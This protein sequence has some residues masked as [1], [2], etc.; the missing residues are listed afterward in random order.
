VV[1][2]SLSY[3]MR[4][5]GRVNSHLTIDTG[6]DMLSRVT[7]YQALLP[8]DT[9][10]IN[11]AGV[12]IPPTQLFR[13]AQLIGLGWYADVAIDITSRLKLIPSLR[14]DGYLLDGIERS[15]V[16]PRLV[17]RYALSPTLSLKAYVGQFSQPP[18]PEALD[19]RFGNPQVGIEHAIHSGLGYEWNPDR[20]WSVDSEIYYV[21]RYDLAVNTDAIIPA[22][23]P[24]ISESNT[25]P[26]RRQ[27]PSHVRTC[28]GP[29]PC[30]MF[31]CRAAAT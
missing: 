14:L 6:L 31:G 21:N 11:N 20:L 10:L 18:Q 2:D 12:D 9:G 22:R 26:D 8:I 23:H 25:N 27:S 30:Q 16:D 24:F 3:R 5:H 13:G 7:S 17:A 4:I 15:S 29:W 19:K 1:N 28:H